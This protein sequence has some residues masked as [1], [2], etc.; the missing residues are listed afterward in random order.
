MPPSSVVF[1][2]AVARPTRLTPR[3]RANDAPRDARVRELESSIRPAEIAAS[4]RPVKGERR[5]SIRDALPSND[6]T[7]AALLPETLSMPTRASRS[8]ATA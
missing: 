1:S 3:R 2:N 5:V 4:A 8:L 6:F 7:G